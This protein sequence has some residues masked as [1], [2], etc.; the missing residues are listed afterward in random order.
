MYCRFR[1]FLC[2]NRRMNSRSR[3]TSTVFLEV[4]NG[5]MSRSKECWSTLLKNYLSLQSI[6]CTRKTA[7]WNM[8]HHILYF[9]MPLYNY[10]SLSHHG[11]KSGNAFHGCCD[12]CKKS[13]LPPE[14]WPVSP[15]EKKEKS[16]AWAKKFTN[17]P[18]LTLALGQVAGL[19][20]SLWYLLSILLLENVAFLNF[21]FLLE[22]HI[23]TEPGESREAWRESRRNISLKKKFSAST[24]FLTSPF[25]PTDHTNLPA[26][27]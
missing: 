25:S 13:G 16:W 15:L 20:G 21:R 11:A 8:S 26:V 1:V 27:S 24:E 6:C 4:K 14:Q 9:K 19:A 18:L 2:T 7:V 17:D 12:E 3:L 23:R 10:S 5:F 22:K